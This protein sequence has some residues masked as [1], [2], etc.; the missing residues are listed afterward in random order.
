MPIS[1]PTP[2]EDNYLPDPSED[3]GEP[4]LNDADP[5]E[6]PKKV[7]K[8][9]KEKPSE[10]V[11]QELLEELKSYK[12]VLDHAS[13][14]VQEVS[15]ALNHSQS[16]IAELESRL[17]TTRTTKRWDHSEA[18]DLANTALTRLTENVIPGLVA[19]L[20]SFIVD[21]TPRASISFTESLDSFIHPETRHK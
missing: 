3:T 2:P 10:V 14:G 18:L 20:S 21:K 1:T 7:L 4:L 5:Q 16:I 11:I 8:P 13:A 15:K 19:Q 6:I 12:R 9:V 17:R